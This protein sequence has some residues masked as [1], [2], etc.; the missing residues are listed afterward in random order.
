MRITSKSHPPPT[1]T[2]THTH[3]HLEHDF[4]NTLVTSNVDTIIINN[5]SFTVFISA[6]IV[7]TNKEILK[8]SSLRYILIIE[9]IENLNFKR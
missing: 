2:H 1:H 6:Y 8:V 4:K 7:W 3:T 5:A 9:L